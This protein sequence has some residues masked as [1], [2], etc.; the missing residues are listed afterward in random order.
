MS[1]TGPGSIT[2]T[3]L[4]AQNNMSNQLNTLSEQLGTGEAA[5]TYSGLQT[6]AGLAVQLSAQ[7]A[8]INGYS[9]TAS[10]I[11]TTL[12]IAQSTLSQIGTVG[13]DVQQAINL[14]GGFSLDNTGQTATQQSAASY[15]DQILSLLNTQIGSN[16]L[17]SGS[18]TN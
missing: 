2:A 1:I 18:A 13:T 17:F 9:N 11:G 4:M 12:S 7:L 3:N 15:L 5:T 6:Q 14:Q 16:Y 10:T 8:A